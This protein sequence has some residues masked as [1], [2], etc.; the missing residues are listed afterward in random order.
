LGDERGGHHIHTYG[1]FVKEGICQDEREIRAHFHDFQSRP[2]TGV[3]CRIRR[4]GNCG[5]CDVG[6]LSLSIYGY[7][8]PEGTP[9]PCCSLLFLAEWLD[10]VLQEHS[11]GFTT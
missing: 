2:A 5:R 7:F 9:V 3:P 1:V 4:R 6:D 10:S 8:R 11:R